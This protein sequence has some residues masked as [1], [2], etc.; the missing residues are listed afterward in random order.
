[1]KV[2]K[3]TLAMLLSAVMLLSV[4]YISGVTLVSANPSDNYITVLSQDFEGAGIAEYYSQAANGYHNDYRDVG[5]VTGAGIGHNGS[6]HAIKLGFGRNI[7]TTA[8]G[9]NKPAFNICSSETYNGRNAGESFRMKEGLTYKLSFYYRVV[10]APGELQLW[11]NQVQGSLETT[12]VDLIDST[13]FKKLVEW[14]QT[15]TSDYAYVETEITAKDEPGYDLLFVIRQKNANVGG[16]YVYIDDITV[17]VKESDAGVEPKYEYEELLKTTFETDAEV[18]PNSGFYCGTSNGAAYKLDTAGYKYKN[19]DAISGAANGK[20]MSIPVVGSGIGNNGS[21][22]VMKLG[23]DGSA[24]GVSQYRPVF[25]L[26]CSNAYNGRNVGQSFQTVA[27]ETYKLSFYYKAQTINT[28]ISLW[29][30]TY[31]GSLTNAPVDSNDASVK[32]VDISA[33][34]NGYVL[35]EALI[36]ATKKENLV[37]FMKAGDYSKVGGT[38][39]YIDDITV[40]LQKEVPQESETEYKYS[41][42]LTATFETDAEVKPNSGFYC[43]TSNG[44]AYKLDTAGYKYKNYDAISGAA[45]GKHMSIP[46]VGSGIGNNGSNGVMKL[47][48]D[49]SA[50]GVSQYRPV[51]SLRCSN[52]Y[53]GRNVGQSFQTVANETYKL[54]FYYKAQTINTPISLWMRT[55]NGSL[56]NAPVDSN[57]ASVKLVDISKATSGYVLVEALITITKKE[58]LVIFM[59]AG[60]YSA[61]GGTEVYI[62]DITVYLQEE[63]VEEEIDSDLLLATFENF[64]GKDAA[65]YEGASKFNNGVAPISDSNNIPNDPRLT[66]L[67]NGA[68]IGNGGSNGAMR[69]GYANNPDS[70]NKAGLPV[71]SVRGSEEYNGR[72]D[73]QSFVFVAGETYILSFWYKAENINSPVGLYMREYD[74]T[75]IGAK[76][77]INDTSRTIIKLADITAA[78]DGYVRVETIFTAVA[79]QNMVFLMKPDN[80]SELAGTAVYIDDISIKLPVD[81]PKVKFDTKGG[82]EIKARVVR[83]GYEFGT[84]PIPVKTGY[85]FEGWFNQDYTKAYTEDM[86]CPE[87]IE[88]A[89]FYAKWSKISSEVKSFSTSFEESEYSVT[90]YLNDGVSQYTHNNITK[91]VS[92][93]KNAEVSYSGGAA[94]RITNDPF[95]FWSEKIT[96]GFALV[97]GDGSRF[98]VIAGQRYKIKFYYCATEPST[99]HSHISAIVSSDPLAKNAISSQQVV[100]KKTIH[101]VTD[102]W[103]EVETTFEANVTG[104]VYI[105]LTAR[106]STSEASSRY[107]T[108]Y[109]DNVSVEALQSDYVK[110]NYY[111]GNSLKSA[112]V[113]KTG[114]TLA[115]P[116]LE[117]KAGY[118]FTGWYKDSG[119]TEHVTDTV[120]PAADTNYY[121]GYVAA[122]YSDAAASDT[123]GMLMSFEEDELLDAFYGTKQR[124]T[125]DLDDMGAEIEFIKNDPENARTGKNYFKM[126]ELEFH[127]SEI[128]LLLYNPDGKYGNMYLA[129]RES[130]SVSYWVKPVDSFNVLQFQIALVDVAN[131]KFAVKEANKVDIR[132]VDPNDYDED[133]WIK[134]THIVTNNSDH[135]RT[136]AIVAP[137]EGNNCYIDDI[138][139]NKMVDV[140]IEFISNGGST[141][142]PMTVKTYDTIDMMFE[143]V[144]DGYEFAGWYTDKE[145][146][147]LFDYET[148]EITGPLTLYAAWKEDEIIVDDESNNDMSPIINPGDMFDDE[149]EIDNGERPVIDGADPVKGASSNNADSG[150]AFSENL[151]LILAI[152][153]GALL[154]AAGVVVLVVV[155]KKKRKSTIGG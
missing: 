124:V 120:Y 151:I 107:H 117:V 13:T 78:T 111:D 26:R 36:T 114:D 127:Y 94:M 91:A 54:S 97:N 23:Y 3:R 5:L 122:D 131:K 66:C 39:V 8:E 29:M 109:I 86:I 33:A 35:V 118:E 2:T 149:D 153:G 57:D 110:V 145:L 73:A 135:L 48:Y 64:D 80:F 71:F 56:T 47:G 83:P 18:K 123:T 11:A 112:S 105:T 22:G 113:G 14:T 88:G 85:I 69:F 99:A 79:G 6:N 146:K 63:I 46:V 76:L 81:L 138:T 74:K 148:A 108:A 62:D 90:P 4:L 41:E 93:F 43:G 53:N 1:M 137:T 67:V 132:Y 89:T 65:Y 9:N 32:L 115:H 150:N 60:D 100:C 24:S 68:G 20:H 136:V 116:V 142:E 52:A 38:A 141:V 139:V 155:L 121:A 40:Y 128:G 125:H 21:N 119:C 72:T 144:R 147:N 15:T 49:G 59:K 34:T 129:P 106:I 50:S 140:K 134:V 16:T 95:Y 7:A 70:T 133:E 102:D 61:V 98:N 103:Q 28:P 130:Y 92:W 10:A 82:D 58:N 37:I 77:D 87:D 101:G 12:R 55:Y 42:Q 126:S 30:R 31:N 27:N 152:A 143:P 104:S 75:L 154:L 17:K 44:A 84:L 19:Y 45:N 96:H 25:S 51:F